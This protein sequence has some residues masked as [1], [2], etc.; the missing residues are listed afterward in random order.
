M[1]GIGAVVR[2]ISRN[3]TASG[4]GIAIGIRYRKSMK[5]IKP[6]PIPMAIPIPN[7][8]CDTPTYFILFRERR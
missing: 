4:L 2:K 1:E 5:S 8:S 7:G 6:I 3:S